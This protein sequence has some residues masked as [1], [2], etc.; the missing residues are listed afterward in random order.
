[1][2]ARAHARQGRRSVKRRPMAEINVVPY[3]DVMLVLLVIFMVT[4]PLYNLGVQVNLPRKGGDPVPR[5]QTPPVI[6]VV[7]QGANFSWKRGSDAEL[8]VD[9]D[10]IRTKVQ[11]A[12]ELKSDT[13]F[14]VYGDD[15]A[16]YG[17]VVEAFR[18]LEEAGAESIGLLTD[19]PGERER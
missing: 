9:I 18:V 6:L 2:A 12:L 19:V 15:Q 3:I 4:A 14:Y 5:T 8:P 1:M 7:D 11:A 17:E 10:A 13:K 16:L